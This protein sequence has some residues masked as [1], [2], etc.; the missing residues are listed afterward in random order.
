[1]RPAWKPEEIEGDPDEWRVEI[2]D[3]RTKVEQLSE[4]LR[5]KN[6]IIKAYAG[7]TGM[8]PEDVH[9]LLSP[10]QPKGEK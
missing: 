2:A 5:E 6:E 9:A 3:L 1:M 4:Y 8:T 7:P 10:A